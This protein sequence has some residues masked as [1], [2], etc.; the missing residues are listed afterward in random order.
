MKYVWIND[1]RDVFTVSSMCKVLRVSRSGFYKSL[2][3]KPS[4]R[5]LRTQ[6]IREQVRQLHE[7]SH[8]TYGS[9]KI[10]KAMIENDELETACRKTVAKA[11]QEMGL[12][13]NK[14][15]YQSHW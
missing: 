15:W 11:M 1:H 2:H 8:C 14:L 9:Y 3:A 10:S 13:S 12:K 4:Q 5:A 6:R 7:R